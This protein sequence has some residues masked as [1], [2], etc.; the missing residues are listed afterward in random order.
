MKAKLAIS[1]GQS[2]IL[3]LVVG[4]ATLLIVLFA[5][6]AAL[7]QSFAKG[8]ITEDRDL[9][10]GM[11]VALSNS[12]TADKPKVERATQ[13]TTDKLIGI[14]TDPEENLVA[15]GSGEQEAYVQTSGTVKAFVSNVSGDI[16]KGDSLTMS[17]IKGVL[18]HAAAD[19]GSLG[20]ALEDF[21]TSTAESQTITADGNERTVQVGKITISLA[22]SLVA[23]KPNQPEEKTQL[24]LF[25][26]SVIGK[27]IGLIQVLAALAIFLTVV[28]A[29]GAII[30]GAIS[31]SIISL[32]RN[33]F[34]KR[35]IQTELF[36]IL[37]LVI[38]V[39]LVGVAAIYAI[40][41]I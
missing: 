39:M 14:T 30:Y 1:T 27:D 26:R 9:R 11:L 41:S 31:S 35:I 24:E 32:G 13:E 33:P 17:P 4:V 6:T 36:R 16:K 22:N 28:V 3:A 37:G 38:I 18:M 15:L 21:N 23:E 29:E 10:P 5:G 34:S 19:T 7:A 12:S 40:V 25:A 20:E 8:Y 2:R